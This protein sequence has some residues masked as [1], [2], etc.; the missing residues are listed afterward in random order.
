MG[1]K[2]AG[3]RRQDFLAT[4]WFR[5]LGRVAF[6]AFVGYV[7]VTYGFTLVQANGQDM[8]PAIKDGDLCVIF[9]TPLMNLAGQSLAQDDVIVYVEDGEVHVG[10]IVAS[11]GDQIMLNETG[12]L[13]INGIVKAEEIMF[14]TYASGGLEYPYHVPDGC[15]FVLGDYRTQ[16]KD[17][18]NYGP[19][20]YD[21]ILGKVI[22]ILRRRG[23]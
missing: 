9:R 1:E 3:K 21:R 17:S 18:R 15:V 20:S 22:S 5:L 7:V 8:F 14:P 19:I 16:T 11:G 2:D 10:R 23:L 4:A 6:L 13:L 12:N